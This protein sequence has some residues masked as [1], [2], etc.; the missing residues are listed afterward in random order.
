MRTILRLINEVSLT[1]LLVTLA[2]ITLAFALA[3]WGLAS[4]YPGLLVETYHEGSRLT[5]GDALYFSVV[6]LSSLGYGDIRPEG[7]VRLLAG[8]EV[9]LGLSFFGIIVAKISSAKQDYILRRMYYADFIDR[10]LA[11]F[12]SALEEHRKLY[13]ITS[14]MLLD[15][16]IDP[17]LTTTFQSDTP[18]TT[19]FY[20]VHALLHEMRDLV[21]F[22][23]GNGGFFGDVSDSLLSQ[24]FASIQSMMRHTIRLV[25]RD[26]EAACAH[27][28]CGNEREVTEMVALAE[29]IA[30]LARKG[31]R[32]SELIE[33][34]DS[35]L[36][37]GGRIRADVLPAL[38]TGS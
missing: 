26:V 38:E 27:V 28:L 25:E 22:E 4:A 19:L 15:G 3:Y 13:R 23:T 29:E 36:E 5:F 18:E 37:L 35:I 8:L 30:T 34:C 10:K 11:K 20:Q 16:D 21:L 32:N 7:I 31:S 14:T 6:T 12:V 24:I 33:Q 9:V 2:G 1:R 17:D